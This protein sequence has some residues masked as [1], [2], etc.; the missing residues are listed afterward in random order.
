MVDLL[1]RA[2]AKIHCASDEDSDEDLVD[3][4]VESAIRASLDRRRK[5][6]VAWVTDF[7]LEYAD[8]VRADHALFVAAFRDGRVGVSATR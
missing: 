8:R 5:E 4:Q 3:F 2:T 7:G 1:G 6:F